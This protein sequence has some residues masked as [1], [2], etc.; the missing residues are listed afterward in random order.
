MVEWKLGDS[1]LVWN[2]WSLICLGLPCAN[3]YPHRQR[4][5]IDFLNLHL[6]NSIPHLSLSRPNAGPNAP[7]ELPKAPYKPPE[8][9]TKPLRTSWKPFRTSSNPLRTSCKPFKAS[10]KP[11][12]A[13]PEPTEALQGW[14]EYKILYPVFNPPPY[15]PNGSF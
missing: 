12:K 14:T 11:L 7:Y 10:A 1:G 5:Q 9:P 3:P 8:A 2:Y 6:E 15:S 4:P 13:P